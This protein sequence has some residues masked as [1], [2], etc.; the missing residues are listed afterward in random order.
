MA[1]QR[2]LD[3]RQKVVR[4]ERLHD[5]R[6]STGLAGTLDE[7]LL[8]ES[9]EEHDGGDVAL[10]QLL[11]GADAVELRHLDIHDDEVGAQLG[12]QSD[13]GLSITGLTDDIEAVVA[14]DLDD[15]ETDQRLIFG[16]DHASG[17]G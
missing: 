12:R 2:D 14:E 15:V 5:V 10:V 11:G 6:E 7:L 4:S 16:D 1:G 17:C 3:R 8:A 13:R 9:R